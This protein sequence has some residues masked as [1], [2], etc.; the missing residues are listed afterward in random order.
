MTE[1]SGPIITVVVCASVPHQKALE[2]AGRP[3][4]PGVTIQALVDTG[5]SGTCIDPL[6]LRQLGLERVGTVDVVTPSTG[7]GTHEAN[8][9][10]IGL[11]IPPAG[12][13]HMPHL[14]PYL[15]VTESVLARNG[16]HALIGRD[17]L[18]DCVL[19]Y[20]GA[21]GFFTLAF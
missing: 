13:G 20:N 11:I 17:V 5:A 14:I 6:V 3:V 2:E 9:Y 12:A 16:F 4:P 21:L 7:D 19:V 10:D 8:T 18:K 15:L 1:A